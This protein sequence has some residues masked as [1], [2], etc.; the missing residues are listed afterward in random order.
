M[1]TLGL[2]NSGKDGYQLFVGCDIASLVVMLL[3]QPD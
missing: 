2:V 3:L 1:G